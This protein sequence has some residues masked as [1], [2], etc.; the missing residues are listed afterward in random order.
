VKEIVEH[1]E[2]Y[3]RSNHTW[4]AAVNEFADWSEEELLALKTGKEGVFHRLAYVPEVP[5]SPPRFD[6]RE[7][8]VVT[9]VK[10][11]GQPEFV[12][13]AGHPRVGAH[14]R[15][16]HSQHAPPDRPRLHWHVA[17]VAV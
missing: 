6:W 17:T 15:I 2:G 5:K 3:I 10:D 7:H 4:Y 9:K 16:R 1:N 12:T 8:N 11:Q 13:E 14:R